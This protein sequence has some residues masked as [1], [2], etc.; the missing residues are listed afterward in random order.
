MGFHESPRCQGI[1]GSVRFDLGR[2]EEQFSASDEPGLEA[3]L[4]DLLE[5][6]S[7]DIEAIAFPDLRE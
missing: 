3:H 6:V 2:V 5:E 7:E 4:D 1:H